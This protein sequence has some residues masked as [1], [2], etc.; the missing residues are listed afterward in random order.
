M[1]GFLERLAETRLGATVDFRTV[2]PAQSFIASPRLN[3]VDLHVSVSG[4]SPHW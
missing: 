1:E 2:L 3:I 4:W